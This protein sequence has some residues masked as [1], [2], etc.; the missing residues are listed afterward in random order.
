MIEKF[1]N[2]LTQKIR[3]K[4]PEVDDERAEII[5]YGLEVIIGETPKLFILLGISILLNIWQLALISFIVIGI[6]RSR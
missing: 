5:Q 2:F 6:Y 4:M 1:C 3:K